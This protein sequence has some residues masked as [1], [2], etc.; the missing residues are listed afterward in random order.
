MTEEQRAAWRYR[1]HEIVFEADTPAGKAFDVAL[2][3]AILASVAAV[4]LESVTE[5]R[6]VYGPQLLAVEWFFTILFTI[7]Y[8]ARLVSI[9]RPARYAVSFFGAVDLLSI[10]PTYLSVIFAG[11]QSLLVIRVLR[12]LRIFRVL[13]L[14]HYVSE[15]QV[16]EAALL[17]SRRKITVFLTT[18]ASISVIA[19]AS[20][21]LIEGEASGFTSIPR[22]VYWAIVT[23]TTVGYGNIA[24]T[25]AGGQFAAACLMILGY[26]IIAV[27]TGI[28]SV[29][30]AQQMRLPVVSTQACLECGS[31]GHAA[32]AS[33]C[34]FCG[35]HMAHGDHPAPPAAS[36][37][38]S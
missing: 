8:A 12:L 31:E 19:G 32:D 16:L 5:I 15:A 24:P 9:G 2:L 27:P 37:S 28:V 22:G 3:V 35:A 13:K 4:M 38:Q 26:A 25:T 7:E 6:A 29:E 23:M 10:L 33:Y 18:V 11:A 14:R 36:P 21:Y 20:M 34:K 17:Q 1:L 30:I